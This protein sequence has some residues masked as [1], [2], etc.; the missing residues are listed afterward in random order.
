MSSLAYLLR[1]QGVACLQAASLVCTVLL[2]EG[3]LELVGAH[4]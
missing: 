1:E 3:A 4:A 2:A